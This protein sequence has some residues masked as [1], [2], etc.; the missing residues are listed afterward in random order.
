M[1]KA[2]V[3]PVQREWLQDK[4]WRTIPNSKGQKIIITAL[5]IQI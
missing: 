4:F 2:V 3:G 5:E 1:I